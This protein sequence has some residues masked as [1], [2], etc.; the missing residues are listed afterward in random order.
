MSG[1]RSA[2]VVSGVLAL[3]LAVSGCTAESPSQRVL[4]SAT[5]PAA[6]PRP[7][8]AITDVWEPGSLAFGPDGTLYTTDCVRGHVFAIDPDGAVS[9]F[10]GNGESST[11]GSLPTDDVPAVD[12][13]VHCPAGIGFDSNGNLL[14]VDH[15]SNRIRSIDVTGIIHTI[16]GGG[17]PG[18]SSNDGDLAGDGGPAIEATL[19]EPVGIAFDEEGN[20]YFADR[21]NHA[22]RKVGL[23]GII[24]TVAGTGDPGFSGDGGLATDAQLER[25]QDVAVDAAGNLYI[26]DAVNNRIRM[27]DTAGII[28]TFAGS[29]AGSGP[30]VD[31]CRSGLATDAIVPDP[32]EVVIGPPGAV[33]FS[34]DDGQAVCRVEGQSIERIAGTGQR[35]FSG[36]GGPAVDAE[37]DLPGGLIFDIDGNL[38]ISDSGNHRIRKVDTAGIITTHAGPQD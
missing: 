16:V 9:V 5:G 35:G 7:T 23:D 20:L 28:T 12:S 24:T 22:V 34:S 37:F 4:P 32:V 17:P 33:Y 1:P 19:Q 18:T 15:A 31:P 8:P 11:S 25:P 21:D 6:T 26:A 14:V 38:F 27:V 29:G 3:F 36:D 13:P 2:V 30:D 10:A